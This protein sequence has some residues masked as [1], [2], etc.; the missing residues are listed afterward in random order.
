MF[1]VC[2]FLSFVF[3]FY[4]FNVKSE[5]IYIQP[6]AEHRAALVDLYNATDGGSW[7]D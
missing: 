5:D 4:S 7:K 3:L 1:R 6:P 2:Q